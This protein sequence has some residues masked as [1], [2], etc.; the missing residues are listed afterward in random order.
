VTG[1]T[2]TPS[3][4]S[5]SLSWTA[6]TAG[7]PGCTILN[8]IIL[9]NG[10]SIGTSTSPSYTVNGLA[11]GTYTYTVEAV[12]SYGTGLG[13]A[14]ATAT[15]SSSGGTNLLTNG[16]F[17][18][19]S[20]GTVWSCTGTASVQSGAG[21]GGGYAALLTPGTN[22]AQCSQTVSGLAPGTTV[23]LSGYLY[24][25]SSS[26]YGYI[27]FTGGNQIGGNTAVY[28]PYT[29]T[30][31]VPPNGTVSVYLQ[32]YKQQTGTVD[33]SNI[34]LT[35]S[36]GGSSCSAAPGAVTALGSTVSGSNVIVNWTAPSNSGGS[37][38]SI[39]DYTVTRNGTQVGAPTAPSYSDTGLAA[40]T[41][42]Y[43][44][45]ATNSFGT[46]STSSTSVTVSSSGGG[47][48][49]VANGN[50]A[51]GDLTNW[52]CAGT[53]A[54]N[55]AAAAAGDTYGAALTA[56]NSTTAQCSQ[57]ITGLTPG[58]SY[59]LSAEVESATAGVYG[60]LGNQT[61]GTQ[62]GGAPST[63]TTY[64]VPVTAPSSGSITIYLQVYKEQT[65]TVYFDNV[66]LTPQ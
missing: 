65:G 46:G 56:S 5:V 52:S 47:T 8:Y 1:L 43:T 63:W 33:F 9:Q 42:T 53:T 57:T 50:F 31:T 18:T 27:G 21:D 24:T 40:G 11:N 54:V 15:V 26:V 48:N 16:N 34:S 41:Y 64:T 3:G 38:C 7:G 6:P 30:M 17:A 61:A 10:N 12:N 37:N 19:G 28:S 23:T 29:T 62:Q 2:A 13:S 55:T 51:T 58:A 45:A 14:S 39:S 22:T 25:S 66:N 36:T 32:A 20:F 60:Y 35:G 4:S 44:V 49:L 59:S